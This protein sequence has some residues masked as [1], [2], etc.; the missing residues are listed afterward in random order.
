MPVGEG[1]DA[2]DTLWRWNDRLALVAA[3]LTIF[4]LGTFVGRLFGPDRSSEPVAVASVPSQPAIES[5]A[6]PE[7]VAAEV[8]P[9]LILESE[10]AEPVP[11]PNAS[12]ASAAGPKAS[13]VAAEKVAAEKTE[14]ATTT[15]REEAAEPQASAPPPA[16]AAPTAETSATAA[17]ES[18]P[19]QTTLVS[20]G[21]KVPTIKP[22]LSTQVCTTEEKFKDRKLNTALIWAESVE[23]ASH[24]A[25][26]EEKLVFLIHVSGNFEVPG[27]T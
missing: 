10:P 18:V 13:E 4:L 5:A 14:A 11:T 16:T 20:L 9:E 15:A 7:S 21:G 17:P 27:F 23:E 24:Q 3:G 19:L 12:L 1:K 22:L 25:E 2:G 8:N 6:Q 26:E